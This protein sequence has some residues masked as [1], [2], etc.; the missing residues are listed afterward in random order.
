MT[1][2]GNGHGIMPKLVVHNQP[3][4]GTIIQGTF[5][6]WNLSHG[7]NLFHSSENPTKKSPL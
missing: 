1:T 5:L 7:G 4:D 3:D 6:L 2:I